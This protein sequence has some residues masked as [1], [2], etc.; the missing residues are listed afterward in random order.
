M[1]VG[2]AVGACGVAQGEACGQVDLNP[3][4]ARPHRRKPIAP[5]RR[6]H[7]RANQRIRTIV[8]QAHNNTA[9]RP[10]FPIK[11]AIAISIPVHKVTNAN[12]RQNLVRRWVATGQ[13]VRVVGEQR[14]SEN[15]GQTRQGGLVLH[16]TGDGIDVDF[17]LHAEAHR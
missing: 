10:V 14:G 5:I 12:P 15:R 7:R 13:G 1:R 9:K 11:P 3:V 6:R 2:L 16:G 17:C 4:A 8:N